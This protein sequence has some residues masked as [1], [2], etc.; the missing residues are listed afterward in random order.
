MHAAVTPDTA[1][2]GPQTASVAGHE[3][4]PA[5]GTV[6]AG[7]QLNESMRYRTAE[8]HTVLPSR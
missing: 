3:P 4:S 1:E 7:R 6:H 5:G 8:R 2:S